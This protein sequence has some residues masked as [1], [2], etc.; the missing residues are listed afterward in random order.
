MLENRRLRTDL[1]E[2]MK[3][4][5]RFEGIDEKLFFKRLISNKGAFYE[6]VPG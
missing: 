1:I 5:K 6:I 4:V 3:I 2:A